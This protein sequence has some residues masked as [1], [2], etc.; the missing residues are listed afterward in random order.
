MARTSKDIKEILKLEKEREASA[1]R[2]RKIESRT[3]DYLNSQL[4]LQKVTKKEYL[5]ALEAQEKEADLRKQ[6]VTNAKKTNNLSKSFNR[7]ANASQQLIFKSFGLE[8]SNSKVLERIN[9]EKAL[10]NKADQ[11]KIGALN[12]VEELNQEFLNGL[13]DGNFVLEDAT[14]KVEELKKEFE[15]IEDFGEVVEG[16]FDGFPKAQKDADKISKALETEIPFLDQIESLKKKAEDFGNLLLNPMSAALAVVGFIVKKMV[17]FAM[18][19]KEVRQDLGLTAKNSIQLSAQMSAAGSS[20]DALSGDAQKAQDS[21][22][23][24]AESM[25]RM[26]N[27]SLQTARNFGSIVA[28]SGA[29]ADEMASILELQTLV[30]GGSAEQAV[31][32]IESVEAIAES[33]GLLKSKVFGDVAD[34]AKTQALFFGKSA[35]EIAKAAKEMRKL[36]IEASALNNIAESLLDLE[37]SISSEFELQTLFGK[38]V[39]LNAARRAA[40]ERDSVALSR[41]IRMQLGGQFDL[42]KA[43]FAQVQALTGAFNLSQEQLQKLIQGQDIFNSKT[44]EAGEKA[45]SNVAK[46]AILGAVLIGT[47]AAIVGAF[48]FGAGTKK[49]LAGAKKGAFGGFL[50]G[51]ALGAAGGAA[52]AANE[53]AEIGVDRKSVGSMVPAASFSLGDTASINVS[54]GTQDSFDMHTDKLVNSLG[55]INESLQ[56]LEKKS[57]QNFG[58]L[59]T[60]TNDTANK[61]Q[62]AISEG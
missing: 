45:K 14:S 1:E 33:A 17:D 46:Y 19:A 39:N 26:P 50:I 51:G 59:I 21:I 30:A 41:E 49:A 47:A 53:D 23:A 32:Q 34:A 48:S 61:V 56:R 29:T 8:T 10:G 37:T 54:K 24:L 62:K 57:N 28:L 36:G 15:D 31:S 18:K 27:L 20:M 13:K 25:G 22:K 6:N 52:L 7:I 43:N 9:K 40:F 38:T 16:M 55:T 60:T 35:V 5:A 3:E 2:R 11:N 42:N 12:K 58:T 4:R 44:D